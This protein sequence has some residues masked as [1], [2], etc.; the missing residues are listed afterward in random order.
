[1]NTLEEILQKATKDINKKYLDHDVSKES[2]DEVL[3]CLIKYPLDTP[4]HNK[5]RLNILNA[6]ISKDSGIEE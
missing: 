1:M 5:K 3:A 6:I 2:L 4:N